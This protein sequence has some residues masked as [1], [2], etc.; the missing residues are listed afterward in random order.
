MSRERQDGSMQSSNLPSYG[1]M[2]KTKVDRDFGIYRCMIV[3]VNFIDDDSNTTFENKQ[4]TYEAVILG[5]PKEGQIIQNVK[6]M[7]DYGGEYNYAEKI[8]RPIDTKKIDEKQ[9]SEHKGDIVF[10]G[11]LQGNTRAP[12]IIGGGV[13][14]FDKDA[15]GAAKADGFRMRKQ[16]NG[17]FEEINKKGEF[18]LTRKGGKLDEAT[19][20]LTPAD[21]TGENFEARLKFF[22]NKMVWQD[23]NSSITFEKKESKL[24]TLVGKDGYSEVIDGKNKKVTT[25]VG[26][27]KMEMDDS[28]KKVTLTAGTT[29][30]EID[31][32]SGKIKLT[33]DFV[34][35]GKAVSDFAV[36]FTE[37]STA[38]NT[39]TH[40]YLPGP[41]GP[42]PTTPPM[43]PLL[44]SVAST[45]V[46]LQP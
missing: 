37:L 44:Q 34:D 41:G 1:G 13:Q 3:R 42:T 7:N 38:F 25:M 17:V 45:T 5:G 10:V 4:V 33:S 14:P 6:A 24:T 26:S 23:P 21:G 20:I 40:Q 11:F 32:N 36:L 31:G 27:V 28:G 30:V 16:Y 29:V 39:H 46:K 19:G 35:I 18:E 43:A 2:A 9:I 12:V 8:Y 15:T 22:E